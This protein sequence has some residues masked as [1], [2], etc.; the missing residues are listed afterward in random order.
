ML[1]SCAYNFLKV[2][3]ECKKS[4]AMYANYIA[5]DMSDLNQI[6]SVV[7]TAAEYLGNYFKA[8]YTYALNRLNDIVPEFW[9]EISDHVEKMY[10]STMC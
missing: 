10:D 8:S 1:P 6:K 5:A 3:E 7:D 2:V 9:P 4:G